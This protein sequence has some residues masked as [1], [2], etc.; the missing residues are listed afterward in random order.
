MMSVFVVSILVISG[1]K[2]L[3]FVL[4]IFAHLAHQHL[5]VSQNLVRSNKGDTT[6]SQSASYGRIEKDFKAEK[7]TVIHLIAS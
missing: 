7:Q 1:T 4:F 3:L 5:V 6:R 2:Q